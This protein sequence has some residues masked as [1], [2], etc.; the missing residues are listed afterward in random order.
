MASGQVVDYEREYSVT[1]LGIFNCLL[2]GVRFQVSSVRY[3]FDF[4]W[5]LVFGYYLGQL[6][7]RLIRSISYHIY[8]LHPKKDEPLYHLRFAM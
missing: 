5:T 3:L 2:F 7:I 1:S 6:E 8:M 4:F